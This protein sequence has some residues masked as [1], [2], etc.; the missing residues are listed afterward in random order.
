MLRSIA[1]GCLALLL[2]TTFLIDTPA[3]AAKRTGSRLPSARADELANRL[4]RRLHWEEIAEP[5][6]KVTWGSAVA[7]IDAPFDKVLATLRD[8]R[9]YKDFLPHFTRS[10]VRAQTSSTALIHLEA[11]AVHG[12]VPLWADVRMREGRAAGAT[13]VVEG[14]LVEGNLKRLDARWEIAPANGGQRTV[15][16]F[17]IFCDIDLPFVTPKLMSEENLDSARR[18]IRA[19]RERLEAARKPTS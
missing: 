3:T 10:D 13:H 15:M 5:G 14:R 1:L 19:M 6:S 18:T 16:L 9:S 2:T 8:Y 7:V 4:G 11:R 17:Q 12:T